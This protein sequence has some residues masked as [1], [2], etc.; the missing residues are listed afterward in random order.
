[1][2]AKYKWSAIKFIEASIL[3]IATHWLYNINFDDLSKLFQSSFV[4][5]PHNFPDWKI[6]G[7]EWRQL[8]IIRPHIYRLPFGLTWWRTKAD[9]SVSAWASCSPQSPDGSWQPS[10]SSGKCQVSRSRSTCCPRVLT[11]WCPVLPPAAILYR[12]TFVWG[13]CSPSNP[14]ENK[15][16]CCLW[17]TNRWS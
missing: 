12:S 10:R 16:R 4:Y 7:V 14:V 6:N 3:T 13:T 8:S 17:Q 1:M 5:V 2:R 15:S 9:H 11:R